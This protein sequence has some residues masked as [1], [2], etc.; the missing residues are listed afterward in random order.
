VAL[1]AWGYGIWIVDKVIQG[2]DV[3]G[4]GDVRDLL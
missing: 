1:A 2:F 3:W 4:C